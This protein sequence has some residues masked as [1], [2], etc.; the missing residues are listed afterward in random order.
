[1]SHVKEQGTPDQRR[2]LEAAGWMWAQSG[3]W[4]APTPDDKFDGKFWSAADAVEEQ[5]RRVER[6][7]A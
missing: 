2:I 4:M 3:G 5:R 1:M 6:G 7:H